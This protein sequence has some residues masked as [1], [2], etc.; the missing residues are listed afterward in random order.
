MLSI[1]LNNVLLKIKDVDVV[2]KR[3]DLGFFFSQWPYL[4]VS[5]G[6]RD[7][8]MNLTQTAGTSWVCK[9]QPA[10][11]ENRTFKIGWGAGGWAGGVL[12]KI[13]CTSCFKSCWMWDKSYISQVSVPGPS[14]NPGPTDV[15]KEGTR[16]HSLTHTHIHKYPQRELYRLPKL[17][18]FKHTQ[19]FS[20]KKRWSQISK[21]FIKA[22]QS[23]ETEERK[24]IWFE[25]KGFVPYYLIQIDPIMREKKKEP[26]A[27]KC[28][29]LK[30]GAV[31]ARYS[32]FSTFCLCPHLLYLLKSIV[33]GD[34]GRSTAMWQALLLWARWTEAAAFCVEDAAPWIQYVHRVWKGAQEEKGIGAGADTESWIK[35]CIC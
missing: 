16:V 14:W 28:I 23:F 2:W 8:Y 10:I 6:G 12:T 24:A 3:R 27:R 9:Y 21:Y 20:I 22:F 5:D 17:V 25:G 32:A 18:Y 30:P 15:Y 1:P 31:V 34:L 4:W 26:T 33:L 29:P 13:S 19:Y 7:V 35:W 11:H